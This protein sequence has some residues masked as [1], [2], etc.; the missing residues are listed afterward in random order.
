MSQ[1]ASSTIAELESRLKDLEMRFLGTPSEV[2]NPFAPISASKSKI[3]RFKSLSAET[4]ERK[5]QK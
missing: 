2:S 3:E 5:E 4:A 1:S